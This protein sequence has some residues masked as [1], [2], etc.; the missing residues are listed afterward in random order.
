MLDF[1][2]NPQFRFYFDIRGVETFEL[3]Q[4]PVG[5]I[6]TI[7]EFATS[8]TYI[9]LRRSLSLPYTFIGNAGYLC[10]REWYQYFAMARIILRIEMRQND[11]SYKNIYTGKLNFGDAATTDTDTGFIVPSVSNDFSANIDAYDSVNY[12]IDIS[13]GVSVELPSLIVNETGSLILQ[14]N[15]DH[16]SNAFFQLSIVNNTQ[17]S[18]NQSLFNYDGQFAQVTNPDYST[19]PHYIYY[20][21]TDCNVLFKVA[22]QGV[23]F[24]KNGKPATPN[25]AGT[26]PSTATYSIQIVKSDG[27]VVKTIFSQSTSNPPNSF[28]VS[29]TFTVPVLTGDRLFLYFSTT[30]GDSNYG[31][32]ITG[33]EIDL[34]YK[35]LS[36]PTM[37]KAITGEQLFA[38]LLQAMNPNLNSGPNLPV[39]YQSFLLRSGVLKPVYFTCSDSIRSGDGSFYISGAT[40]GQ[41]VYQVLQGTVNYDGQIV[42]APGT[43]S[44]DGTTTFTQVGTTYAYVQKIQ[45]IFVGN[46]YNPGDSLEAGGTFLVEGDPGTSIVYNS[47]SVSAGNYF[48]YVLGQ[49]TFTA[50]DDSSFVK[51]TAEAPK[52]V[53]N[54]ADFFQCIKSLMWG[55]AAIGNNSAGVFI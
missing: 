12:E 37:T 28:N 50:S 16:R 33:G 43:F 42:S 8:K 48:D 52:I 19:D 55:N 27:T 38:R 34:S 47:K 23:V 3:D 17:N 41:G 20:A 46:V 36:P 31:F 54:L 13:D 7:I 30:D 10:R 32:R 29:A 26:G 1:T 44:F 4:A 9:G 6:E 21:R 45:S 18:I 39:L 22:I 40:I 49:D 11:L 5:W 51:Q 24:F 2:N 53:T 35:T 14:G 25:G 15:T